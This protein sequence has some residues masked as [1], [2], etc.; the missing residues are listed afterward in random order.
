[1]LGHYVFFQLEDSS[2]DAVEQL[3]Q[4]AENLLSQSDGIVFFACGKRTADLT[5]PVN[6]T[7]FEIGLQI[8]FRNRAAHDRYQE[9]PAHLEFIEKNKT[10]WS[11]IRVF[12][13]DLPDH[14]VPSLST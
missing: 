13:L 8:V 2:Q 5:R 1:M 14:H 11:K 4:S 10:N 12:D 6:D 7:Q 9:A 3:V